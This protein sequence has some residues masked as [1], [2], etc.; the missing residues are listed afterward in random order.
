MVVASLFVKPDDAAAGAAPP[1][2]YGAV[3]AEGARAPAK[4]EWS[5]D[6]VRAPHKWRSAVVACVTTALAS[7]MLLFAYFNW[8]ETTTYVSLGTD[9][10][11]DFSV[12][13]YT[14]WGA[15]NT[16][17]CTY[18][19]GVTYCAARSMLAYNA[20][21][22]EASSGGDDLVPVSAGER[23][24]DITMTGDGA[25][26]DCDDS[27][28]VAGHLLSHDYYLHGNVSFTARFLPNNTRPDAA[29][30]YAMACVALYADLDSVHNE[31]TTCFSTSDISVMHLVW[32]TGDYMHKIEFPSDF[33]S[34]GDFHDYVMEW[35]NSSMRWYGDGAVL[36]ER[37]D[38]LFD[39]G[40]GPAIDNYTE[41]LYEYF[42]TSEDSW[43]AVA[44]DAGF[45]YNDAGTKCNFTY[46]TSAIMTQPMTIRAIVRPSSAFSSQITGSLE[47]SELSYSSWEGAGSAVGKNWNRWD[48]YLATCDTYMQGNVV[49]GWTASACDT[50]AHVVYRAVWMFEP[51]LV[52]F[53]AVIVGAAVLATALDALQAVVA[54]ACPRPGAGDDEKD[55]DVGFSPHAR[56]TAVGVK[57][58]LTRGCV[59]RAR[60]LG[61]YA[62]LCA[63]LGLLFWTRLAQKLWLELSLAAVA[64]EGARGA[65]YSEIVCAMVLMQVFHLLALVCTP[66]P[67]KPVVAPV[68][69]APVADV[70]AEVAADDDD[71]DE[72]VAAAAAAA[73]AVAPPPPCI[74]MYIHVYTCIYMYIHV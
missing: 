32:F 24:V 10:T 47:L 5:P 30:G 28:A 19:D 42:S 61:W 29:D 20:S 45:F 9:F 55:R 34:D 18:V 74:Y 70:F 4:S 35:T 38:D 56:W 16:P 15:P 21:F 67:D 44:G 39:C 41:A 71:D 1:S 49:E 13:D 59:G 66:Y 43:V 64:A 52:F 68:A 65:L 73:A 17:S 40:S 25:D 51:T 53:A 58:L 72:R 37:S 8:A 62:G 27:N 50:S 48:G 63:L 12:A 22:F 14:R 54:R 11:D 2:G 7:L 23:G 36:Y 57:G 3:A 46:D 6:P 31:M 60:W 69:D 33:A 26:C